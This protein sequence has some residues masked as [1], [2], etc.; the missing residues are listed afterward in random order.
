AERLTA[1]RRAQNPPM[2]DLLP[3]GKTQVTIG[4]APGHVPTA[5]EAVV[6]STQHH[7]WVMQEQLRADGGGHVVRPVMERAGLGT[8]G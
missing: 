6:V 8:S 7:V 5:V 2:P 3:D 1:V 4:Y